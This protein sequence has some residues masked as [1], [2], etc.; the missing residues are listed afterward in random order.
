MLMSARGD[1]DCRLTLANGTLNRR[2]LDGRV[3][4]RKIIDAAEL[5]QVLRD[6]FL[7]NLTADESEPL[8]AR[9]AGLLNS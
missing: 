9:L 7:L 4:S 3:E 1:G 6:E 2:Y 8:Q 5:V